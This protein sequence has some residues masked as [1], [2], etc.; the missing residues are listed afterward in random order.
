MNEVFDVEA[1]RDLLSS[2][3]GPST[4]GYDALLVIVMVD[5]VLALPLGESLFRVSS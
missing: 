1:S 5:V 2:S 3:V 4:I